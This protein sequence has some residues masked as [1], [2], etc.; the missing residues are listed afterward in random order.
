MSFSPQS[1]SSASSARS[2]RLYA[3]WTHAMPAGRACRSWPRLTLLI[4]IPPI[5]PSA[6]RAIISA[7]GGEPQFYDIDPLHL[8]ASQVGLDPGAQLVGPLRGDPAAL[9]VT[10][11]ANLG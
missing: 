3:F 9:S 2:R 10:L 11:S 8:E 1:S 5:L 6:R 4:P 7:S